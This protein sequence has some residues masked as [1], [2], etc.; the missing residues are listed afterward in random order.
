MV[1]AWQRKVSST[2]RRSDPA[3]IWATGFGAGWLQPAPGTWGSIVALVL[4]WF[5]LA[6]LSPLVQVAVFMAYTALSFWLVARV[7]S[8]YGVHDAGEIVADEIAGLWL[9]LI[10]APQIWWVALGGFVLF[11]VLD[12]AKPWPVGWLDRN[13]PGVWGVMLDDLAAGLITLAVLQVS[14]LFM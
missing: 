7:M 3:V 4:W 8:R 9:A 14:F 12:I 10:A 5:F 1:S 11:R 2:L 13:V 6:P